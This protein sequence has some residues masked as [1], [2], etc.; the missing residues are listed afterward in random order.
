MDFSRQCLANV[1]IRKGF[2]YI[3]TT[4]YLS[5]GQQFLKAHKYA[6]EFK[7][8]NAYIAYTSNRLGNLTTAARYYDNL[9][10]TDSLRTDYIEAASSVYKS[11][12]DTTKALEIIKRG[13]KLL[14][15]D[16]FL[17]LDEANIYN[18][19][20]DY[21]SL[22]PLLP[23]LLDNNINN[24]DIVLVAANCYDHLYEYDKAEALY[25]RVIEL[26]SS[27]YDPIF[28]L[29]LLY[30]KKSIIKKDKTSDKSIGYAQKWMEKAYEI[31]PNSVPCMQVLQNIYAQ[32]G[33]KDQVDKLNSKLKQITNQ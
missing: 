20:R 11:V 24:S 1:F 16:K 10:K 8:L 14:P 9:A 32:T 26:N 29:G 3:A 4:D 31:S 7:Q 27:V 2:G 33:N 18:N 28:N 12:G 30:F 25:L 22:A 23:Q 17:L 6:P 21:K 5:A 15:N 13:R 19:R